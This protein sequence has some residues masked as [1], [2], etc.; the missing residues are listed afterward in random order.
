MCTKNPDTTRYQNHFI[1]IRCR[2][3][4]IYEK[5]SRH[6]SKWKSFPEPHLCLLHQLMSKGDLKQANREAHLLHRMGTGFSFIACVSL[7][8]NVGIESLCK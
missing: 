3:A 2:R 4:R 7:A 8:A 1:E 6:S 5:M